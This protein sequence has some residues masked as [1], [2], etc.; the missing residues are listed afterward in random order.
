MYIVVKRHTRRIL[1]KNKAAYEEF[2]ANIPNVDTFI[3]A[4][5]LVPVKVSSY[6]AASETISATNIPLP[7]IRAIPQ[8]A[9][10]L[11]EA[12]DPL[13]QQTITARQHRT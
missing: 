6:R 1:I 3:S 9:Y 7:Q 12:V 13:L 2:V 11:K 4:K 5:I 10:N 8:L